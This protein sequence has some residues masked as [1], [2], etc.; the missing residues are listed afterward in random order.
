MSRKNTMNRNSLVTKLT[1]M[2]ILIFLL[3]AG[4]V[5]ITVFS[6]VA[7]RKG[8]TTL[9]DEEIAQMLENSTLSREL[10]TVF[11]DTNLLI[12]TFTEVESVLKTEGSRLLES[13]QTSLAHIPAE[14]A[15]L[16]EPLQGFFQ[17]FQT[18][19]KQCTVIQEQQ[20]IIRANTVQFQHLLAELDALVGER[21]LEG[22]QLELSALDSLGVMIPGYHEIVLRASI[23]VQAM[24][25]AHL[26]IQ[27]IEQ[28]YA[29]H[30][31]QLL[32]SLTGNLQ[33][34]HSS[35]RLFL[36]LGEQLTE[37]TGQYQQNITMFA[38]E[39]AGLQECLRMVDA[40]KAQVQEA[41]MTIDQQLASASQDLQRNADARI[42][43]SLFLIL[44]LSG[45]MLI[46]LVLISL[47][48]VR[49]VRPLRALV[50]IADR[51]AN[52]NLTETISESRSRDEIGQLTNAIKR[53]LHTLQ[54]VVMQVKA[55]AD[56][57]ADGS[58]AMSASAA[59]MSEGATSQ[60]AAAEEASAS[61]EE[62]AANI[63]QN[64]DN[65]MQTE[66]IAIQSARNAR[67]SGQAVAEVV[68][69]MREIVKK[70]AMIE[71][72]TSQTR[73][74]SLNATIEAARAQEH[75]RGFAVVASEV[76]ALAERSQ[77]A[78]AEITGLVTTSMEVAEKAGNMLTRLVPDIQKTAEL[79]QEISAASAEQ[80]SGTQQINRA[81]QQLDNVTQQ[82]SATSEELSATA[83]E[84]ASQAEMLQQTIAF[85]QIGEREQQRTE[86]G[87]QTYQLTGLRP[88]HVEKKEDKK[89][90]EPH[91]DIHRN[92]DEHDEE[93]ERY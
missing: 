61:M 19:L 17:A 50:V 25:R 66:K 15:A 3:V 4:I 55:S 28:N 12:A 13:L 71:D 22:N 9:I 14:D 5:G 87:K 73:M 8:I 54:T 45:G 29:Q 26:G 69:A 42:R 48:G 60:A 24:T 74:L 72:I 27:E 36:P 1:G 7:V 70:V 58:Q 62:M 51:L 89:P 85:F 93:F 77:A 47:Y 33:V 49:M 20:Q 16:F 79:V 6:F 23:Q 59:E 10:S 78:S 38:Q 84:L 39:L 82:N 53:M 34:I 18:L 92:G 65:A 40:A 64:T 11:A 57:V 91:S 90:V 30:I 32:E 37:L 43:A 52:G 86:M 41:L 63:S 83:E 67:D 2:N 81:I 88:K 76:R 44:P 35:G 75:G 56:N 68:D 80:N 46:V 31:S 21:M